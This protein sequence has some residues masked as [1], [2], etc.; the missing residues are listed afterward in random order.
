MS[1]STGAIIARHSTMPSTGTTPSHQRPTR[2]PPS[3]TRKPPRSSARVERSQITDTHTTRNAE[4]IPRQVRSPSTPIGSSAADSA[5][6]PPSTRLPSQGVRQRG[7]TRVNSGGSR[8]SRAIA[9]VMRE[10]P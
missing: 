1:V 8:P 3:G 4:A 9:R 7:C 5:A 2:M 10:W 6:M